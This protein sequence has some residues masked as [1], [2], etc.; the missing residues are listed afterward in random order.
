MPLCAS[1]RLRVLGGELVDA[2]QLWLLE[3]A[4]DV[5]HARLPGGAF[6]GLWI[7]ARTCSPFA[8][9]PFTTSF[10]IVP[11]APVTSITFCPFS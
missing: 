4:G 2:V 6:S 7:M 10:P 1:K 11:V 3:V 8:I 5:L 9:S